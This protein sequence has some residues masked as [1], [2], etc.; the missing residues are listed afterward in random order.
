MAPNLFGNSLL[1]TAE[2]TISVEGNKTEQQAAQKRIETLT[3]NGTIKDE[4]K[5]VSTKNQRH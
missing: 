2:G 4:V 1:V 5:N 3:G